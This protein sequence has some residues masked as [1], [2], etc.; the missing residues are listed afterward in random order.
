MESLQIFFRYYWPVYYF[1]STFLHLTMYLLIYKRTSKALSTLRYFLYSSTT[2]NFVLATL[3]FVT[4]ARN[5]NNKVSMGLLCDGFC[6]FIGPAFCFHC[7]FF[8]LVFGALTGLINL[9]TLFYRTQRAKCLDIREA[10]RKTRWFT[11]HYMI[12]FSVLVVYNIPQQDH[13]LVLMETK[14][15]HP[16]YNYEI[17]EK[18]GGV[19]NSRNFYANYQYILLSLTALYVPIIGGYW[20]TVAMKKLKSNFSNTTSDQNRRMFEALIK[21]LNLQVLLPC[22]CYIPISLLFCWNK[23]SGQQIIFS[24][25]TLAFL[26]SLPCVFDPMIQMYFIIPYRT[27]IS[28]VLARKWNVVFS[29]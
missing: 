27:A 19:A 22:C 20:K 23:Y 24:Q 14:S 16:D 5:V 1:T 29:H 4:Q 6:K 25:Y 15:E 21:G 26:I 3:G 12:P 28:N 10:I 9:H 11:L 18:F 2:A 7:Y 17:Y 13:A 8:L